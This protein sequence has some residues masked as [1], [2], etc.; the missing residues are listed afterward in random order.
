MPLTASIG[1]ASALNGREASIQAVKQAR[2]NFK[3]EIALAFVFASQKYAIE[4]VLAGLTTQLRN[5]PV[6]GFGTPAQIT[7]LGQQQHSVVVALL[8]GQSNVQVTANWW[9]DFTKDSRAVAGKMMSALNPKSDAN[10]LVIADGLSGEG[11]QIC[12][13]VA[14]GDYLLAGCLTGKSGSRYAQSYQIGGSQAGVGGLAAALLSGNIKIGVG[15][16]HGWMPV[17]KYFQITQA[18]GP[19]IRALDDLPPAEIYA[20]LFDVA[21][22]EWVYPPL[23]ELIR[24]YPLGIEQGE[25]PLSVRTPLRVE[26]DGSFRMDV[27][28]EEGSTGHLLVGNTVNC[29]QAVRRASE[30][31]L[32]ALGT[33]RPVFALVFADMAWKTLFQTHPGSETKVIREVLGTSIPIAGGYSIGQF[34]RSNS[35]EPQL[36]NQHI[37]IVLFGE[38]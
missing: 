9:P 4:N 31:A 37:E 22:R 3:G 20:R 2:T 34:V 8:G 12:R 10:L 38:K 26:T 25:T 19:W 6:L 16:S 13:K 24:L 36:L 18:D 23:N 14:A 27:P 33:A 32:A 7:S 1:Q 5:I 28:I 11:M 30:Q 15:A 21:A 35:L 29:I 17:G